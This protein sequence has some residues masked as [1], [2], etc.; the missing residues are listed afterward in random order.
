MSTDANNPMLETWLPCPGHPAYAVS[1]LGRVKRVLPGPGARAGLIRKATPGKGGY[2]LVTFQENG[3][4]PTRKVH[5]L[6]CEAFH[7][8]KP[9]NGFMVLHNDGNPRNNRA[10]NLRWST[11]LD[12]HADR[13]LHG[14]TAK[15]ERVGTS[16]LSE[17]DVRDILR[18]SGPRRPLAEKYQ[19]SMTTIST[20]RNRK[21]W[22]HVR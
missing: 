14:R 5:R 1:N 4:F 13:E 16:K 22:A 21:G 15:G 18:T 20:I 19:V 2:L 17:D 7:G 8:G 3:R 12:N 9:E 11:C 6:V 10:D